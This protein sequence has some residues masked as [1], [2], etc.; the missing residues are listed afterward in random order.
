[1]ANRL[2]ES[3]FR[4]LLFLAHVVYKLGLLLERL[5][6]LPFQLNRF[7]ELELSR[8]R[9]SCSELSKVPRH[10]AIS[11]EA[12]DILV[13]QIQKLVLW[14]ISAGIPYITLYDFEGRLKELQSSLQREI[15]DYVEKHFEHSNCALQFFEYHSPK[16]SKLKANTFS[17]LFA[18][19]EDGMPM[20]VRATRQLAENP[21]TAAITVEYLNSL[22]SGGVP[23]P[24]LMLK[25]DGPVLNGCLPWQTRLTEF[26]IMEHTLSNVTSQDF[27]A[28]LER[29]ATISQRF[30]K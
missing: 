5:V 15:S 7:Q 6:Q 23:E 16:P 4:F 10:I 20:I 21:S 26:Y 13:P 8:L 3:L 11:F 17:I 24:E 2:L 30:G 29:Y 9:L 19:V 18:A 14:S 1:M 27:K 25:F 28:A 12:D 22:L